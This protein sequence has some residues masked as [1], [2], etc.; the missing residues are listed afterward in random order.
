MFKVTENIHFKKICGALA[1]GQHY[2]ALFI[3]GAD[4]FQL[5]AT[6]ITHQVIFEAEKYVQEI[7][8]GGTDFTVTYVQELLQHTD[9]VIKDCCSNVTEYEISYT[10]EYKIE[11]YGRACSYAI[12]RFQKMAKLF[13]DKN[14]PLFYLEEEKAPLFTKYKNQYKQTETEEAIADTLC[15]YLEK[16]L[17]EQ[18]PKN[19][20]IKLV[21]KMKISKDYLGDKLALKVKILLDLKEEGNFFGFMSYI[22]EIQNV[23]VER[24]KFYTIEF[25]NQKS[26]EMEKSELQFLAQE[27]VTRLFGIIKDAIYKAKEKDTVPEWLQL[28]C[29]ALND[30][31]ELEINLKD[32]AILAGYETLEHQNLN[33]LIEKFSQHLKY[34]EIRMIREFDKIKCETVIDLWKDEFEK[35]YKTTLIGCTAQCPFCGEQCDLLE[36]DKTERHRTEIHRIDCIAGWRYKET[37]VMSTGFCPALVA[38]DQSFYKANNELQPYKQYISVYPDWFIPPN[39]TSK[40]TMYWKWFVSKYHKFLA[41]EY[42]AEPANVPD[43][44]SKYD[45]KTV[46]EDLLIIYNLKL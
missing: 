37:S 31:S 18:V 4:R 38:G 8:R 33:N 41:E 39:V 10:T 30:T 42:Q 7:T 44:W 1:H 9:E 46:K 17:R 16:P 26:I 2:L 27:E 22:R 36:H 11:I 34:M 12:P 6:D 25:A 35:L 13:E 19:L 29:S 23:M 45:W 28:F 32:S 21:S 40:C 43:Q 24:I 14:N 3:Q 20:G 15:A 5:K